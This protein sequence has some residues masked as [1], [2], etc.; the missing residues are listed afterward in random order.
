[1]TFDCV[2]RG[3]QVV[4]SI[5][6]ERLDIGIEGGRVAELLSEIPGSA[7]ETIDGRGLHVFPGVVDAHVHFNDPGRD[8][9]EGVPTGSAALVAGGGTC[10]I[11]MP[12]NSSPPTLDAASFDLKLAA[13]RGRAR[14]D[15]ALWGGL[16]PDNLDH[17]EP[18]AERG[19]VGF[20]AFLS[21]SGIDDFRACDDES[22]YRG[23]LIAARL[24]LPVAV[25]AE[26]QGMTSALA[27]LARAGGRTTVRD[28]LDSR[29][30]A[31]EV[32][33]IS[34]ALMFATET[35]CALHVVHTSSVRGVRIIR[36]AVEAGR[37][38][39]TCETCPHY[40]VFSEEDV[41][42][43]GARAKCAPPLRP[44]SQRQ[45]LVQEVIEGRV[46]TIG[47]DHSPSPASLKSKTDFFAAWGGI[48]GAQATLRALLTVD[49]PPRRIAELTAA[50]VARRFRLP[51][52]GEIQVGGD[53]DLALVDLSMSSRIDEGEL[54]DRHHLSPY[55]GREL[56]GGVR[57][58]MLRGRTVFLDGAVVDQ[59]CG[60]FL[61]PVPAKP[62]ADAGR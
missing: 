15:F 21:A 62:G 37:C 29:P 8:S 52:K 9:W 57:R 55:V 10:F 22:L 51:G 18:L 6:V 7:R 32:E 19:V 58:T 59:P 26:N 16:T 47:S 41:Q 3:A 28:Y 34:R 12:L 20:K 36:Q 11:D 17:L 60:T 31:A 50:N 56:K 45:Q 1:M 33:A 44:E 13:C 42:R 46:D 30:I 27:S 40:L 24:G 25:H 39:A 4:R 49:I 53:A 35:G 43:M 23:M 54:L 61:R 14:A 5:G 38:D 48:S 2:I